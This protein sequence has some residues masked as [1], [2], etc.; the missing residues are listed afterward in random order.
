M[1]VWKLA[2][3]SAGLTRLR[4]AKSS[5]EAT[6]KFARFSFCRVGAP[7][8]EQYLLE[9]LSALGEEDDMRVDALPVAALKQNLQNLL[10]NSVQSREGVRQQLAAACS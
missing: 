3:L 4:G 1:R 6:T 5:H 8:G 2:L 7:A 9:L 10:R